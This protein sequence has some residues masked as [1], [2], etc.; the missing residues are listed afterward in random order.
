[1]INVVVV[2]DSAFVRTTMVTV[3]ERDHDIKV[4]ATARN[5]EDAL[6]CIRKYDPDVVTL[7]IEMPRMDGL[8]ALK[9]IMTEMPRPV[10]MVSSVT[11][12]GAD[13]TLR[14]LDLASLASSTGK[15]YFG[16]V[17]GFNVFEP[18]EFADNTY[19]PPC[20]L[21]TSQPLSEIREKVLL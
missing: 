15:L 3:L 20:L 17:N 6:E 14:A 13:A 19:L 5:G 10:L 18:K 8:T 7:D 16:G 12:D 2:D 9:H 1:M 21:Y 11:V 4:V